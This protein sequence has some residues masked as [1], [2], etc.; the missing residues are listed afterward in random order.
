[1]KNLPTI[2]IYGYS[3]S[4]KTSLIVDLI[5]D[6]REEGYKVCTVKHKPAEISIDQEGKDTWKH[7]NAGSE[8]T[9]FSTDIETDFMLPRESKLEKIIEII[10]KISDCDLI[11][12]E[13]FKDA[14]FPK[15]AVGDIEGRDKTLLRFQDNRGEVIDCIKQEMKTTAIENKLPG[16]DCGL[17]G[18]ETCREMAEKIARGEKE[19]RDCQILGK[20]QKLELVVDGEKIPLENFPAN[21]IKYGLRGMLETLKGVNKDIQHISLK[22]EY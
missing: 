9:V 1:M 11:L 10:G 13:G 7:V 6:L 21:I 5:D 3:G 18:H 2:V 17:C 22:A 15:V 19:L 12:A 8:M 4:G 16:L 20:K 14:S